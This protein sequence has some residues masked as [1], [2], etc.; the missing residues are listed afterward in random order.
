MTVRLYKTLSADLFARLMKVNDITGDWY[1]A[2]GLH[3]GPYVM[4]MSYVAYGA[5][6][7]CRF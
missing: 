6:L 4:T 3:G 7:N 2:R 1:Y 5:G